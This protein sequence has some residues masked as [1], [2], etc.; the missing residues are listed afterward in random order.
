MVLGVWFAVKLD[1][2]VKNYILTFIPNSI[3]Y[4]EAQ[5]RHKAW[6]NFLKDEKQCYKNSVYTIL[7][8]FRHS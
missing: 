1:C 5:R 4:L 6:G 2:N 8:K 7:S 3:Q